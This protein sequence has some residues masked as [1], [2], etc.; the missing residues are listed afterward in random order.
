[1]KQAFLNFF[2]KI[3]IY[4]E[5]KFIFTGSNYLSALKTFSLRRRHLTY[6]DIRMLHRVEK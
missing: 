6:N 4:L 5:F 1:M 2:T 3:V